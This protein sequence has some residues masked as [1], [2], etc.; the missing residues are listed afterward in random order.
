MFSGGI[1]KVLEKNILKPNKIGDLIVRVGGPIILVWEV[2][3]LQ[4]EVKRKIIEEDLKAV[5][6][7]DPEM[8]NKVFRFV[9]RCCFT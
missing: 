1:G 7:G 2:E 5:Q 9:E 4:V 3:A 8:A 6:R